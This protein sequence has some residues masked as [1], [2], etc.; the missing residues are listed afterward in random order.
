MASA[1]EF[2]PGEENAAADYIRTLPEDVRRV[3]V[4]EWDGAGWR[5]VFGD[6]REHTPR[7]LSRVTAGRRFRI[8]PT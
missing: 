8:R 7:G 2:A 1:G 5:L 6:D 3:Y 4:E